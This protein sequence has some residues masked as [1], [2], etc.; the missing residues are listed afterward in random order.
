M[1]LYDKFSHESEFKRV[2][3]YAEGNASNDFEIEFVASVAEKFASYGMNMFFSEKQ[4]E[5]LD[6]IAYKGKR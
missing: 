6:R 2:L 1:K 3:D 4:E 5:I